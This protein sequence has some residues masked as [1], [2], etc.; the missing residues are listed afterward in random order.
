MKIKLYYNLFYPHILLFIVVILSGLLLLI[1]NNIIL[2]IIA[3]TVLVL[4]G[5]FTVNFDLAHP[6]MWYSS[7]FMLYSIAYPVL[8]VL[9]ASPSF[10][11]VYTK[12]LM[13]SQWLALAVFLVIVSPV[14]INYSVLNLRSKKTKYINVL[15]IISILVCLT[16]ILVISTGDF[17]DKRSI[18][19]EIPAIMNIGYRS[20]LVL[21]ILFAYTL[22]EFALKNRRVN[23]LSTFFVTSTIFLTTF[24]TGERDLAIRLLIILF[25][26]YY[27]IVLNSQLNKRIIAFGLIILSSLPILNT[28]KYFGLTG[29]TRSSEASLLIQFLKSDFVAA[30]RNLQILLLD[31]TSKGRFNGFTFTSSILR[32]LNLDFLLGIDPV[33]PVGWFANY[34]FPNRSS[35]PGFTLVGDGY[36]NFGYV[37]IIILFVFIGILVRILYSCSNK[38]LGFFVFYIVSIPI[39]MYAIRADLANII[40]PLIRHNLLTL[41][42]LELFILVFYQ[43]QKLH[44]GH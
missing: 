27:I 15:L 17:S 12:S 24:F 7:V 3:I 42:L 16:T 9:G 38:N 33:S 35:G 11:N 30:S 26:I 25:L 43:F 22:S 34:Y 40:S 31:E 23:I 32:A 36:I 13:T 2:D 28:Y 19:S 6:F 39:F 18:Y 14:K 41:L 20:A 21:L 5:M 29:E 1:S 10:P 8:Y 44:N 37:G 4:G